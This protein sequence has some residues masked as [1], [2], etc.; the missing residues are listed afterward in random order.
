MTK[1]KTLT[2]RFSNLLGRHEISLFRGAVISAVDKDDDVLFHNH[3]GDGF[4]YAY[5]EIQYKSINHRAVII[6]IGDGADSL[7]K[8]VNAGDICVKIGERDAVLQIESTEIQRTDID[9]VEQAKTYSISQWLPLN[10]ENYAVYTNCDNVIDRIEKLQHVLVGNIISMAKGL[11]IH[12]DEKIELKMRDIKECKYTF[13]KRQKMMAFDAV[14]MVNVSLPEGI[15]LGKGA[16][17]G[18]GTITEKIK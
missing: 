9:F 6:G 7:M 16:S 8:I 5:P 11:G 15:G 12:L 14:F 10:Q 3:K 2:V 17:L 13:F 18:F 1:I 4:R